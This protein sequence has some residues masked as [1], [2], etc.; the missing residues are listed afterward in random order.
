MP[1]ARSTNYAYDCWVPTRT[2]V[3]AML[4]GMSLRACAALPARLT[5]HG[6]DVAVRPVR[7]GRARPRCPAGQTVAG[8]GLRRRHRHG[9]ATRCPAADAD[10]QPGRHRARSSC[11][12]TC[13]EATALLFQ[14]QA[15]VP[16]PTGVAAGGGTKTYTFTATNPGTFLYEAGLLP[17]AQHQVAMG[18]YGALIVRPA[19]GAGQAYADAATAF[20]DEALLVLSEIDPALNASP[21]RPFD[22][23]NFAPKYFLING[24][25]YPDTDP[26][27]S[28][29]RQQGPAALRQRRHP[30]ALDGGAGPAADLR[31]HGRQPAP[32]ADTATS[33]PRRSPPGRPATPSSR[34]RQRRRPRASSR[35]TTAA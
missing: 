25:A 13:A 3:L 30:A 11:T 9:A 23:R 16:D 21:I 2:L 32:D 7:H 19:D 34:C 31:R 26:I 15:M 27:A 18:L 17:N 35:S 24:K 12:T 6:R 10:R 5:R 14:G 28:A 20:D 4:L 22:M 1:D 29:G 8:L 33:R